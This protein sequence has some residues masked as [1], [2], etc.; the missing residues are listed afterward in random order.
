MSNNNLISQ[1]GLNNAYS[2][3]G[4]EKRSYRASP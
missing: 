1:R 3:S 2:I 4:H